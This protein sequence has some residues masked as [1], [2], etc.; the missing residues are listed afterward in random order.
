MG[1]YASWGGKDVEDVHAAMD[2][3][4]QRGIADKDHLGVGGWSYGGM[5][6]NYLIASDTRFKAAVSGA[7]ISD[8]LAG[9]G[10]DEYIRDYQ[11]ELGLPWKDLDTWMKVSYPFYHADRI[12]TPTLFMGG[13]KDFN[14]TLLNQE[15]MYQALQVLQVPTELVIYPNQFHGFTRPSYIL[16]RYKRWL[17][18]YAKWLKVPRPAP[19]SASHA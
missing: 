13:T 7:S 4:V 11:N 9:F 14:V 15:Q 2:A 3:V 19:A 16:D 8:I 6:T 18:W 1:I 12:K 10:T 5:L 17:D